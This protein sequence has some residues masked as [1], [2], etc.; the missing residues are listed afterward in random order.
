LLFQ[1]YKTL[2]P[3]DPE[4]QYYLTALD[5]ERRHFPKAWDYLHKEEA[6]LKAHS[7]GA[8]AFK[9][10]RRELIRRCPECTSHRS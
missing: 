8:K 5:A 3:V 2:D 9:E 6:I 4:A 7:Y 1:G 10:L